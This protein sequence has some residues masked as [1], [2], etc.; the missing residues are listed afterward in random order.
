MVPLSESS[1]SP[2]NAPSTVPKF[3]ALGV[4][5]PTIGARAQDAGADAPSQAWV[6]S[7]VLRSAPNEGA[8]TTS[9]PLN[10]SERKIE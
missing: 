8:F 9:Y 1:G 3:R 7:C 5:R 2:N 4:L 6:R 10:Y